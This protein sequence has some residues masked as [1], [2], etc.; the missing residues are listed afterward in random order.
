[1]MMINAW[2]MLHNPQMKCIYLQILN[3]GRRII[4]IKL[5]VN[6]IGK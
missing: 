2:N 6:N 5:K 1:M 4:L 3:D